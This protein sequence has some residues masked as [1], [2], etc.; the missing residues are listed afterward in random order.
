[1]PVFI[2]ALV[3]VAV[4]GIKPLEGQKTPTSRA[5]KSPHIPITLTK[6]KD[7]EVKAIPPVRGKNIALPTGMQHHVH[8]TKDPVLLFLPR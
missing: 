8:V 1:M 6:E 2:H 7:D 4:D 3:L 5:P